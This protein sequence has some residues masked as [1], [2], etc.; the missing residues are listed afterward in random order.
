MRRTLLLFSVLLGALPLCRA[1][2][3]EH[4]LYHQYH[5]NDFVLSPA[6]AGSKPNNPFTI[7]YRRQWIGIKESPSFQYASFHGLLG[8]QM[9]GLGTSVFNVDAGPSSTLGGTLAYAYH[10]TLQK[11]KVRLALGLQGT[12]YQYMINQKNL[13]LYV[14]QDN[15]FTGAVYKTM[16]A[17]GSAGFHFY[18]DPNYRYEWYFGGAAHNL[19]QKKFGTTYLDVTPMPRTYF[20]YGGYAFKNKVVKFEPSFLIRATDQPEV[21]VSGDATAKFYLKDVLML[22]GSYRMD[23][24]MVAFIALKRNSVVLG[25]AYDI[26]MRDIAPHNNGSH[27]VTL[28]IHFL[29]RELKRL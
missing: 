17:D 16:I 4:Q 24:G 6:I 10:A 29:R 2:L 26:T 14:P 18:T 22:G 12:F 28:R 3:A 1:Q 15:A 7:N 9:V 21:S 27:E 23:E 25:Y 19:I 11:N 8:N 13:F 20:V 5:F